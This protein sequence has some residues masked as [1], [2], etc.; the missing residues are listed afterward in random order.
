M[1]IDISL[2]CLVK[3]SREIENILV[4]VPGEPLVLLRVDMLYVQHD[5]VRILH[6]RRYLR[7]ERLLPRERLPRGI[8]HRAGAVLLRETIELGQ[9]VDL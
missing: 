8:K 1:T 6:E 2:A 7:H 3:I 9:K 4:R 5:K